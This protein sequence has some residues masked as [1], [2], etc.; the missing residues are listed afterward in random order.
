[1]REVLEEL[2]KTREEEKLGAPNDSVAVAVFVAMACSSWLM[3]EMVAYPR[4]G[5]C[6]HR[7]RNTELYQLNAQ[8]KEVFLTTHL[9][10]N[11]LFLHERVVLKKVM[12]EWV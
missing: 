9:T 6:V 5:S 4:Q 11:S 10:R 2:E 12:D 3:H 1:M 7:L 8:Q